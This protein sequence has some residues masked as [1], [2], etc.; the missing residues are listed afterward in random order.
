MKPEIFRLLAILAMTSHTVAGFVLGIIFWTK[1]NGEQT[2]LTTY[3]SLLC[4]GIGVH[5]VLRM[6]AEGF[7]YIV[8][9]RYT[10][11]FG[12]CFWL[13]QVALTVP[14]CILAYRML[15]FR[16]KVKVNHD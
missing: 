1:R 2:K 5:G 3:L 7:G 16:G 14:S 13:A 12:V 10:F 4:F 15:A 11:G 6:L 9:P 8:H